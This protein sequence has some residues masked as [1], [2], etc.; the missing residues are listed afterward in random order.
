[1][2]NEIGLQVNP[3]KSVAINLS[4]GK[5]QQ[6]ELMLSSGEIIRTISSEERIR[7]LGCTF[8]KTMVFNK[9]VIND[10]LSNIDKMIVS[11]LLKLD[12]KLNVFNQYIFP[13]LI[14]P[15]QAAPLKEIP[16]NITERIDTMIRRATKDIIGLPTYTSTKM[17][18]AP[19]KMR[20]LGLIR[21]EWEAKLQHFSLAQKL[22]KIDDV[23]F[24]RSF[25]CEEE[26]ALCASALE[27]TAINSA[28]M[29][30]QLFRRSFDKWSTQAWQGVGVKHFDTYHPSNQFMS[31]K[32]SLSSSEFTAAVKLKKN[33]ANLRGVPDATSDTV[34]CRKCGKEKETP[35]HVI[36]FCPSNKI[37]IIK[38]HNRSTHRVKSLMTMK[39][40]TCFE[41]VHARDELGSNRFS[42]IIAFDSKSNRAFI[43]DPTIRFETNK[44]DQ[45]ESVKEEK[46]KIYDSCIK[47]YSEKYRDDFGDR[48]WSVHGLWF[49]SRGTVGQSVIDF[50][51]LFKL[52]K[53]AITEISERVLIDSIHILHCHIYS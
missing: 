2:F 22:M 31:T 5:L 8:E 50:F 45:D 9:T 51:N 42:D 34:L 47:H 11:P 52:D 15:L 37:Q 27:V 35:A 29:R 16:A 25:N 32:S 24:H 46:S 4:K 17:F 48:E 7:Y 18:Y 33:Y 10:F 14:Y 53:S 6:E 39:Q 38:R 40:W 28:A 44:T 1:M 20:G 21:C 19:R 26:M 12:Q 49:G 41:E 30:A 13:T 43:V 3:A 36:G 23:V